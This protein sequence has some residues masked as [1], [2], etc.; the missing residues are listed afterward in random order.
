MGRKGR[1]KRFGADHKKRRQIEL[2]WS[3]YLQLEFQEH[4]MIE[5]AFLR[6]GQGK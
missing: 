6:L 5:Y 4:A 1:E 3:S 2:Q